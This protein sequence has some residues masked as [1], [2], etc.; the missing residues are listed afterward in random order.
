MDKTKIQKEA[1]RKQKSR[2]I[3]SEILNFGVTNSQK[4]DI[5]FFLALTLENNT[6]MQEITKFLKKYRTTISKEE[7]SKKESKENGILTV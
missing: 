2:E 6:E 3:V 7:N 1:I 4:V 5:M